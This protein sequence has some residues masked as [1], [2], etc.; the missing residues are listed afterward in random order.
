MRRLKKGRG[1]RRN[2]PS[3]PTKGGKRRRRGKSISCAL[4]KKEGRGEGGKFSSF[5]HGGWRGNGEGGQSVSPSI[6]E[7]K[8]GRSPQAVG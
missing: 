1:G 4:A 3:T 6:G 8:G 5:S 7:K 2:S